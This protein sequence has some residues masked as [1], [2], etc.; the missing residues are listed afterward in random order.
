MNLLNKEHLLSFCYCHLLIFTYCLSHP[1]MM[2]SLGGFPNS[3]LYCWQFWVKKSW[4]ICWRIMWMAPYCF[5]LFT[6][7]NVYQKNSQNPFFYFT[8]YSNN[9]H[10]FWLLVGDYISHKCNSSFCFVL[11]LIIWLKKVL[12]LSIF[13]N[14]NRMK[15]VFKFQGKNCL[16]STCHAFFK[17]KPNY[18]F[19]SLE[20]F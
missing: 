19:S 2:S 12:K 4:K 16:N 9:F 20:F 15:K 17:K 18:R 7:V 3:D 14:V 13:L 11:F 8:T 6:P 10:D 5:Q 1:N